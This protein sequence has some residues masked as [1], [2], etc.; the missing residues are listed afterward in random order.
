MRRLFARMQLHDGNLEIQEGKLDSL[1]GIY[2]VSGTASLAG[3]LNLKLAGEGV[4]GFNI[5]GT[6]TS[7]LVAPSGA[8]E[9]RAAL[10]P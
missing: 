9:T 3:K 2:Q 10:K 1:H 8:V 6:L 4:R 7:P 5:T